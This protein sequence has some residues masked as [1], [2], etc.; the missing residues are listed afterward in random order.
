MQ[1]S[2]QEESPVL[3]VLASSSTLCS[4]SLPLSPLGLFCSPDQGKLCLGIVFPKKFPLWC[5]W[6]TQSPESLGE[7]GGGLRWGGGGAERRRGVRRRERREGTRKE[8]QFQFCLPLLDQPGLTGPLSRLAPVSP[9]VR[10]DVG[11]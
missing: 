10:G 5:H 2:G 4:P 6:M 11:L 1:V 8:P 9:S 7:A 3:G